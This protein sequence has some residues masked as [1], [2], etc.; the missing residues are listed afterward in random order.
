MRD[1]DDDPDRDAILRRRRR[2]ISIALAGLAAGSLGACAQPCL[3][4]LAQDAGSEDAGPDGALTE[5]D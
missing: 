5:D 2:L 4:V 3:R 1:G